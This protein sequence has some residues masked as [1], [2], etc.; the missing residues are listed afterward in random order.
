MVVC[1]GDVMVDVLARLPGELQPGSDRPAPIRTIGGGA[2]AN[3]A[4]WLVAAGTAATIVGR[5][6][7]D[8]F[9]AWLTEDLAHRGVV[10]ALTRDRVL[11]TGTCIV[12]VSPDGERTMVPDAG[13]ERGP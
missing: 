7:H 1:V 13:G 11:A 12:L 10:D 2:A 9:G 4:A 8:P 3:T 6:G 5:I